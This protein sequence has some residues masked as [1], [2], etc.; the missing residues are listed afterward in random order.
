MTEETGGRSP[1]AGERADLAHRTRMYVFGEAAATG[2]VPRKAEIAQALA[3]PIEETN[4]ALRELAAGRVLLLAPNDGEI[5]AAAPFCAVKS[6][7]K[8]EAL[9][10]TYWGICIWDALGVAAALD[11]DATITTPCGDCGDLLT[12]EV[13]SRRLVRSEGVVH[14]GVPARAWWDNMGFT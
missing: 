3:V 1:E 14:F 13:R 9:G 2:R 10:R 12:L 4:A 7:F 11:A 6:G 8:V 5:W